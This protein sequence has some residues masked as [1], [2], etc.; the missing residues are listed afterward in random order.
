MT[1]QPLRSEIEKAVKAFWKGPKEV[2]IPGTNYN[3]TMA[4]LFTD[5]EALIE[6]A[7]TR[8]AFA[9]AQ[10]LYWSLQTI[11]P[12][13]KGYGVT[14]AL[15]P[16]VPIGSGLHDGAVSQF[17]WILFDFDP[18]RPAKTSSTEE[19]KAQARA[20]AEGLRSW[21]S[22]RGYTT[23]LCDSGNGFHVYLPVELENTECVSL[24]VKN[25]LHA[26]NSLFGKPDIVGVDQTVYSAGQPVKIYGTVARKGTHSGERPHRVA[27]VLDT[28]EILHRLNRD[29]LET[30]LETALAE[31]P[32]EKRVVITSEESLPESKDSNARSNRNVVKFLSW[33][34]ISYEG[35]HRT[36]DSRGYVD[37]YF[38]RCEFE[39]ASGEYGPTSTYIYVNQS[40]AIGLKCSHNSC[41][42]KLWTLPY[43]PSQDQRDAAPHFRQAV[44]QRM[45]P[46]TFEFEKPPEEGPFLIIRGK[47]VLDKTSTAAAGTVGAQ[48]PPTKFKKPKV[49]GKARDFIFAPMSFIT[50]GRTDGW[51]PRSSVSLIGGPS[52][53]GK[54]RWFIPALV[55]QSKGQPIHGHATF[56]LP[57]LVLVADRGGFSLEATLDS[58]N[59]TDDV[60]KNVVGLPYA[61]DTLAINQIREAIEAHS[62]MPAVVFIEGADIMVSKQNDMSSVAAFLAALGEIAAYYHIAI[63]GS[64]GSPKLKK[65]EDFKSNRD[66]LFGSAVWGRMTETIVKISADEESGKRKLLVMPRNGADEPFNM[67]FNSASGRL[68]EDTSCPASEEELPPDIAWFKTRKALADVDESKRYWS[69]QEFSLALNMS[70]TTA[71]RRIKQAIEKGLVAR[72]PG[73]R[74]VKNRGG[75][76]LYTVVK[77]SSF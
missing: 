41:A 1:I 44:E 19:E 61:N 45:L 55:A 58:L 54:T 76:T 42:G 59:L 69:T 22:T 50:G 31:L 74:G 40:G 27:L 28:P 13:Y 70:E 60:R 64:V 30:L 5:T 62:E 18:T 48:S 10:A 16:N 51:F 63:I 4:G 35:P 72:K 36:Y 39:H 20:G 47:N 56:G 43:E 52:G 24:L 38:I 12:T 67:A 53:V 23:W 75:S 25:V 33:A 11:S 15:N 68:E 46:E 73:P 29:D 7:F 65:G 21:L 8:S 57:Y 14:N 2:R 71:G 77:A 37:K 34:G 49:Q 66:S 17:D 9:D 3:G 32:E 6:A 26:F